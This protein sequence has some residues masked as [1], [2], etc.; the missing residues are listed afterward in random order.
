MKRALAVLFAGGAVA[1][2]A[3][4][5]AGAQ[6]TIPLA[7]EARLDAGIPLTD[8]GDA[9]RHGVGWGAQ[10]TLALAPTFGIYGAFSRFDFN[11]DEALEQVTVRDEGFALGGRLT[12]GTGAGTTMPYAMLGALFHDGSTGIEAG[13]GAEWAVTYAMAVTPMVRFRTVGSFDYLT[14]GAGLSFRF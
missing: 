9:L 6:S 14:L 12:L 3:P 7:V 5:E 13:L 8:P 2:L 4:L 1:A 11:R 10:A